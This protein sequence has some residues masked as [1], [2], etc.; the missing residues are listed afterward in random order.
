MKSLLQ[1]AFLLVFGFIQAQNALYNSGNIRIHP[2]GNLGFHTNLINDTAFDQNQGLAGFY[3]D[4]PIEVQGSISPTFTDVEFMV[5]NDI[6]LQNSVNVENN[7]NFVEGNVL[8][9]LANQTIH[10]NFLDQGFFTGENNTAKV[11]GFAAIENRAFFSFPVGD[12]NQLRPLM[13]DSE[14]NAPL[15]ICAYFF[16]NPSN[17]TSITQT[18]NVEEKVRNIGTVSDKEFWI[19]QSDV[20]ATVTVSWNQRSALFGIPNTTVDA[21]ILVGWSKQANQ[22]VVIGNTA[23]S[24]D[25]N[26]GFLTSETFV[27]SDYEA[28]T[29]GTIPLPT[30]TFAVNNPTLGNYFLSPN[31]DGT[32]DF[33]VFDGL[34]ESPNNSVRI[35]NR[36]G[37]KVFEKFNYVDEFTGLTNTGSLLLNKDIGL[38]EGIYYYLVTLD[39]LGLEYQG[40]IFLDR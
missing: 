9:P 2:N 10:L 12:N 1:I 15:T 24:G 11:T 5:P 8:T 33:L 21:I 13:I 7:V 25:E 18:F 20:P 36:F 40:F 19:L 35:F 31:G 6:L 37:Q 16:E 34:S 30:D 38:A 3:G 14:T 28:I 22:W 29:F 39:D 26:Q 27:P 4:T 17:P 32:N 23:Q